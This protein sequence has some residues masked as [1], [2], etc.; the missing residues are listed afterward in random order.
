MARITASFSAFAIPEWRFGFFGSHIGE[1]NIVVSDIDNDGHIEMV[2][3]G[4]TGEMVDYDNF[5]YVVENIGPNTY[6]KPG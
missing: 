4:C 2:M 3:P 5:W 6:V 1:P